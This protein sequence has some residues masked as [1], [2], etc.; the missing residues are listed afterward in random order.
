MN[1]RV[2]K[3]VEGG[4]PIRLTL[5]DTVLEL[6]SGSDVLTRRET[7]DGT[8]RVTGYWIAQPRLDALIEAMRRASH[9]RLALAVAGA[10]QEREI[11]LV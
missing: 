8:E 4:V 5:G 2:N 9:G 10:P 6:Q 3:P 11:R 1:I 7:F